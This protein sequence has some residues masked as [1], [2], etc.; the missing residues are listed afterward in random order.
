MPQYSNGKRVIEAT[1]R[2]FEV[3]YK[4]Q[5]YKEY[6]ETE[7]KTKEK[8]TK[9]ELEEFTVPEL[10]DMARGAD[11]SG[12]SSLNKGELIDLLVGE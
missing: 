9:K 10:K 11:V 7:V 12:Y 8:L 5:G 1:K 4:A 6:K 2:A 3:I